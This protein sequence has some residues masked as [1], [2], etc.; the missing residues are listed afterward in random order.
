LG[1]VPVKSKRKALALILIALMILAS[2][3]MAAWAW[4]QDDAIYDNVA[5]T[6]IVKAFTSSVTAGSLIVVQVSA[7]TTTGT[8]TCADSLG[9]TYTLAVGPTVNATFGY[10]QWIFY[11]ANSAAGANT[12][13]VTFSVSI[14]SKRLHI[15]EYSGLATSAVLD[16]TAAATG[17]SAT[18]ASGAATTTTNNQLIFGGGFMDSSDIA[19]GTGFTARQ[20][21]DGYIKPE[22]K[23]GATAGSYN[24]T[25]TSSSAAEWIAQM[26]T[27]KE[28]S[29]AGAASRRRIL[30]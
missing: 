5:S 25:F 29:G 14:N 17:Y 10:S 2:P 24:A 27:F 12:V 15:L 16:V 30:K 3:V 13:T 20:A 11:F 23:N 22:D 9:Q 6:T 26:A 8:A 7:N 18:P 19:A 28:P 1:G 21:A 4:V